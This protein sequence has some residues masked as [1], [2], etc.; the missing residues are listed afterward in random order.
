MTPSDPTV[1]PSDLLAAALAAGALIAAG[2]S[3]CGLVG[4]P[5]D[6]PPRAAVRGT[7]TVDGAPLPAGTVTFTPADGA[8]G[9]KASA[10]VAGGEYV[11][12][13][14]VGPSPGPHRVAIAAANPHAP[15]PDDEGA[16]ARLLKTRPAPP[17]PPLPAAYGPGGTLRG[18]IAPGENEF[19]FALTRRPR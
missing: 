18:V 6:G 14:A 2:L 19:D 10:R 7:V 3:G 4:G 12:P 8:A 5:A 16:A 15:A 1:K 13:A 9:P 11:I 17:P